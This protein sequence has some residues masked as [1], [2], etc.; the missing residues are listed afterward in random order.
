MIIKCRSIRSYYRSSFRGS[1][2][3]P[4]FPA[5][6]RIQ[7]QNCVSAQLKRLG[8]K[9]RENSLHN[10]RHT[11]TVKLI[12]TETYPSLRNRLLGHV[13]EKCV[14]GGRYGRTTQFTFGKLTTAIE[15]I[16][17]PEI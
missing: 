14:E 4:V 8:V 11:V 10:L 1:N 2:N 17:F 6:A 7:H 5:L 9:R 16:T 12:E 15:A 13:I 3:N